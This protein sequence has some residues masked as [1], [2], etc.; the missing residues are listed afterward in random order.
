MSNVL[1][2]EDLDLVSN[3]SKSSVGKNSTFDK[4]HNK[5]NVKF[6]FDNTHFVNLMQVYEERKI[7]IQER[8]LIHACIIFKILTGIIQS[9]CLTLICKSDFHVCE[10]SI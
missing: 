6:L 2:G 8:A 5:K 7:L 10:T 3:L 4:L 1:I 9:I